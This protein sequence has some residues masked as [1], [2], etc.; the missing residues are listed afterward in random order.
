MGPWMADTIRQCDG[1]VNMMSYWTFSDVFEEQGVVKRP[2]Y[3]G[4]GLIAEDGLPKPA[5]NAF[6]LLHRLG[7]TKIP[8]DA[9]DIIATRRAD[10]TIVVAVWNTPVVGGGGA[11]KEVVLQLNSLTGHKKATIY[12]VD[13]DHGS[14]LKGYAAMGSP[15]YL[16]QAQIL[17]L[18]Q[19]AQLPAPEIMS[20][21]NG[22]IALQ[23]APDALVVVE[24]R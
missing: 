19:A 22:R 5:F 24:V 2:I 23:L 20:I 4:Y 15:T 7:D 13:A 14:L 16:T 18:R 9:D 1:L 3:G 10:G 6:K 11:P 21:H 12:R 8:T 17:T